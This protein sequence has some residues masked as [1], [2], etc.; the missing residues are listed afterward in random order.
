[1]ARLLLLLPSS[2]YRAPDFLGAA[3]ALGVEVVVG[4]EEPQTV[5]A[6]TGRAVTVPLTD[7][8]VAADE[9]ARVHART[10]LDA[11][12]AA[13]DQGVLVA[14]VVAERL[15]LRGNPRRAVEAT[16][17]KAALRTAL[18]ATSVPQPNFRVAGPGDDVAA[19]AA[20]VGFPVVVKP[21]GLSG[22]RGV[23]RADDATAAAR[24]AARVRAIARD[25]GAGEAPLLVERYLAG[26]E[27]AVEALLDTGELTV[28]AVFDKPDPL[29]GPF[30][31]ETIYV[32]PSRLSRAVLDRVAA[33]TA[34]AARGL[35]LVEGPIHAELRVDGD[36]VRLL[37]VAARSIGGLCARALRFGAGVSLEELIIR[38][39]VGA[40]LDGLTREAA[41]A[42]VMMLPIP[43]A[44]T[45]VG[46]GGQDTARA[47]PGVAGLEITIP[48]GRRVVPLPEGDRYLG[49]L[50]ARGDTPATVEA[51]L[52]TAHAR[53]DV[54][55][56]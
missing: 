6:D 53:L 51:V 7:P 43:R 16:R 5:A 12:V 30:F 10:P 44:G 20:A 19:L 3:R 24:A 56:E 21:V 14:A 11:V 42:G 15:G 45:L 38:H 1:V 33:V 35:G 39:A 23:I 13:D 22:S 26:M 49:F 54:R 36:D 46:V 34:D 28:L 29:E 40:P 52:R 48:T 4:S 2:T 47:I 50:F 8:E 9:I 18:A 37:E 27:V 55:I 17:D 25:A 31:E 32:T 41:A